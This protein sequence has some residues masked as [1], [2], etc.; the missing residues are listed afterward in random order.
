[1]TPQR[2]TAEQ[3]RAL[4]NVLRLTRPHEMSCDE[5]LH[6]VGAYAEAAAAGRPV[7]PGSELI[8]HHLALCPD[9]R[10]EFDALVAALRGGT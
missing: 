1:M 9:C 7:P 2:P 8:E 10:E 3:L 5:W 4:T 6:G